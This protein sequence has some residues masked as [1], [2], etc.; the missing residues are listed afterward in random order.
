ML[1]YTMLMH[2][3]NFT[4]NKSVFD[5]CQAIDEIKIFLEDK[6]KMKAITIGTE[7]RGFPT[8]VLEN[9]SKRIIK[10]VLT[11]KKRM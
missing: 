10:S 11:D 7:L 1:D 2:N 9:G 6:A 4:K 3:K 5:I 8:E